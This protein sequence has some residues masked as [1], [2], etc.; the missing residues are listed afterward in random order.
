MQN[1]YNCSR[2]LLQRQ[3]EFTQMQQEE[4]HP[5]HVINLHQNQDKVFKEGLDLYKDGS[6]EFLDSDLSGEVTD[7]LS[8]E[9]TVTTTKKSYADNALKVLT[10]DGVMGV[11]CESEVQISND[12]LRQPLLTCF[13]RICVQIFRPVVLA[14][15]PHIQRLRKF[16]PKPQGGKSVRKGGGMRLI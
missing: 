10:K 15:T 11:H 16:P 12:D 4:N 6:L 1:R 5:K 14:E 3:G 7:I 9:I 2:E 13:R 8:T